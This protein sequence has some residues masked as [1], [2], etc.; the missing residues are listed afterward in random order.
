M[1]Y[2]SKSDVQCLG[3]IV[4]SGLI[5][6]ADLQEEMCQTLSECTVCWSASVLDLLLNEIW[7]NNTRHLPND[8][9]DWMREVSDLNLDTHVRTT[10][11]NV[12]AESD[13]RR[14]LVDI[15][16]H[17]W[18]RESGYRAM[19][20]ELRSSLVAFAE[21]LPTVELT[22]SAILDAYAEYKR[23]SPIS[24]FVN[25]RNLYDRKSFA[26]ALRNHCEYLFQDEV[27]R[28]LETA[29]SD[30]IGQI[31]RIFPRENF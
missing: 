16:G 2:C 17:W 30:L 29:I 4:V 11:E 6:I 8:Y 25:R 3:L 20:S 7:L 12:D 13:V 18:Q 10:F 21:R 15:V 19:P 27:R 23:S 24:R 22:K 1:E 5:S 14:K 9:A 28:C 31:E 26:I